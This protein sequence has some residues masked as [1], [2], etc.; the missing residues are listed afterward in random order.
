[1]GHSGCQFGW[2]AN[3]GLGPAVCATQRLLVEPPWGHPFLGILRH[4]GRQSPAGSFEQEFGQTLTLE[5]ERRSLPAFV[6]LGN[7]PK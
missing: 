3:V 6:S 5:R 2:V 7:P 4:S 1:M